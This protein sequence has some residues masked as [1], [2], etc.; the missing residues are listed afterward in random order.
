M[1]HGV[2]LTGQQHFDE[3]HWRNDALEECH[4][5]VCLWGQA[6]HVSEELCTKDVNYFNN[7]VLYKLFQMG[8]HN[9]EDHYNKQSIQVMCHSTIMASC[10]YQMI[11]Q[12]ELNVHVY[13][14]MMVFQS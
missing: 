8:V 13:D 14:L 2:I 5:D 4:F 7:N 11:H 3:N 9:W 12:G 6:C 10:L 1:H